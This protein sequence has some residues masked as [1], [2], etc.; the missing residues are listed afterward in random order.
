MILAGYSWLAGLHPVGHPDVTLSL[1]RIV[2]SVR[3]TQV[4]WY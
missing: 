2:V 1:I 3:Y 4:Y